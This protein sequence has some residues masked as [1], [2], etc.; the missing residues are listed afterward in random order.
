MPQNSI[1][2]NYFLVVLDYF[3]YKNGPIDLVRG[4]FSGLDIGTNNLSTCRSLNTFLGPFGGAQMPQNSRKNY[5]LVVS[6]YFSYKNGPID[7][8]RGLFSSLD[9][10]TYIPP[11][12]GPV[13]TFL[14]TF[15]G[16]QFPKQD[17]KNYF[18]VVLDHFSYKNGPLDLVRGLFSSL[19]IGTCM[20]RTCRPLC[21]YLGQ[22]RHAQMPQNSMKKTFSG[23]FGLFLLPESAY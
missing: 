6:D 21:T 16:A 19:D 4:L 2:K 9:N 11:T 15:V 8:V 23:C 20:P 3:S 1:K 10:G 22:L 17:K 5:F 12:C 7:L 13:C 18:L 14:G